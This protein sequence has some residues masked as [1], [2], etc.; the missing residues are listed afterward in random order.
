[1]NRLPPHNLDME[2]SLISALFINNKGFEH[3]EAIAPDDF[4]KTAHGLIFSAMLDLRKEK[5]PVDL[6]T[7]MEKLQKKNHLGKIGGPGYLAQIADAAPVAVNAYAYA[8][9]I[10]D[11]A[12]VRGAMQSCMEIIDSGYTT[13]DPD[14][15]V[16]KAQERILSL[17]TTSV[18][19]KFF[20]MDQL[21]IDALDRIT[22]AQNTE[23]AQG[24][25]FGFPVLGNAMH[26]H[27]SK[28]IIIAARP[29]MGKT[30][31]MLSVSKFLGYQGIK[32]TI[33][34]IEMDKEALVDR[35]LSE[36]SDINSLCFSTKGSLSTRSMQKLEESAGGLSHLPIYIDD[37]GCKI[38]D[39]ERKCRKAKKMGSQIIFID[40]L[41][42]ISFSAKTDEYMGYTRNCNKIAALKKELRIP[43]VLL[44]QLNR[45]L[46]NRLNKRPVLADLKQ[47][48]AIEED[49]DMVFFI[50]RPGYYDKLSNPG[51]TYDQSATEIILAKNRNGATGVE[52]QVPFK[53]KRGMFQL[54]IGGVA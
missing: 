31:L 10:K 13:T 26:I 40:Q 2:T 12:M 50:F 18:K 22:R 1:M 8:K 16:S 53:A 47:T 43:I 28:L 52:R 42:K 7:V 6:V 49:A 21:V 44:C 38:Q 27:G 36:E 3:T 15:F 46:E 23:Q 29:G 45:N 48:G 32:N 11:L 24:L 41:S 51:G 20:T 37:S 9:T 54:S 17:Q 4:Y 25:N 19:D 39:I 33:I 34:S 14:E 35:F 5:Q 30:A